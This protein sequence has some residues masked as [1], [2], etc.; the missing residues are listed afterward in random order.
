[1]KAIDAVNRT[2]GRNTLFL[3]ARNSGVLRM[4]REH[5]SRRFTTN[6]NE[7]L[8]VKAEKK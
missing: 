4:H 1:M 6:W 2:Q 3:A 5:L 7:I 8:I